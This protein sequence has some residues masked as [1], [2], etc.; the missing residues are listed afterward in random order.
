MLTKYRHNNQYW[1]IVIKKYYLNNRYWQNVI[2]FRVHAFKSVKN[3]LTFGRRKSSC[4]EEQVQYM[5]NICISM[6]LNFMCICFSHIFVLHTYSNITYICIAYIF[7]FNMYLYFI[8]ICVSYVLVLRIKV[9]HASE[10]HMYLYLYMDLFLHFYLYSYSILMTNCIW[11]LHC[12]VS[13][14]F[15]EDLKRLHHKMIICASISF[16]IS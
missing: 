11:L 8:C 10:F 1:P 7:K 13:L 9:S 5:R 15:I 2:S 16:S 3:A 12:N 4:D 14:Y 6:Y